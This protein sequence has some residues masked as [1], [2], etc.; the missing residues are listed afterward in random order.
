MNIYFVAVVV[1]QQNW[2][3]NEYRLEEK[4]ISAARN[5]FEKGG[6]GCLKKVL[7][8]LCLSG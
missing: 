2:M 4:I 1:V 5:F 3:L 6:G 7:T 8:N